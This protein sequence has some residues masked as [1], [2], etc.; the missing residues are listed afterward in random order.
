MSESLSP[1]ESFQLGLNREKDR[2]VVLVDGDPRLRPEDYPFFRDSLDQ[3]LL[4]KLPA[5][6]IA[7]SWRDGHGT[8]Q[9]AARYHRERCWTP[10]WCEGSGETLYATMLDYGVAD[11]VVVFHGGAEEAGRLIK[12][13]RAKGV[14]LRVI[15]VWKLVDPIRSIR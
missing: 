10:H 4:A 1:Q 8:D 15:D 14:P 6:R 7:H 9:L 11:G 3:L 13:V 12:R 2:F 5:V